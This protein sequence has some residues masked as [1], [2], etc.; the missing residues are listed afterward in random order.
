[1]ANTPPPPLTPDEAKQEILRRQGGDIK[2]N[3]RDPGFVDTGD[4]IDPNRTALVYRDIPIISIGTNWTPST[5]RS[6]LFAHTYGIFEMS[7][8]LVDEIIA[9]DRVTATL[10]SRLAGLFGR[11]VR[12]EPAD[13]SKAAREVCDAWQSKAWPCISAD[14]ALYSIGA[15]QNLFG[16]WPAQEIWNTNAPVWTPRLDPWHAR[17]TYYNWDVRKY[18]ALTQDGQTP[19]FPGDSKWFLLAPRGAYRA[20]MWGTIRAI[21][22]PWLLRKYALRDMANFSEV[23]GAPTRVGYTP[24]AADPAE[25][26]Q[27]QNQ[28]SQLGANTTLL[29]PRGVDKD[30]GYGYELVSVG[31]SDWTIFPGLADRCDLHITLAILMQNLTTEVKGGSFAATEA[32]MDIRQAGIE[33]DNQAWKSAL[34]Y[35]LARPF[36]Y[37]NFGDADLAPRTF[38]DVTSRD[39]QTARAARLYSFGQASQIMRQAGIT[40]GEPGDDPEPLRRYVLNEY[41]VKLP[42]NT[43]FAEPDNGA[44][45]GAADASTEADSKTIGGR[46]K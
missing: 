28:I 25:R 23:Y 11:E 45:T 12:F 3:G 41:G 36:A 29:I 42:P 30:L 13:D 9:D 40:M 21:A 46:S 32:H 44:G 39:E 43:A 22:L 16:F 37:L 24:A 2:P 1:V 38:W 35:Q 27:F 10:N 17:Y 6:A 31:A 15:Y 8:Q 20:W 18:I 5:V 34:H 7:G 14:G 4:R 33:A 19:V 26:S